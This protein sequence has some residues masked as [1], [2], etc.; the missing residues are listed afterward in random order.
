MPKTK[1]QNKTEENLAKSLMQRCVKHMFLSVEEKEYWKNK[2]PMLS[3][4]ELKKL[5]AIF[6]NFN[7]E[8]K[9]DIKKIC[10]HIDPKELIAQLKTLKKKSLSKVSVQ[11]HEYELGTA[12]AKLEDSL[13]DINN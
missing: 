5:E 10:E 12:E 4:P 1:K 3:N 13:K 2:I 6:N 9:E 8:F 7:N 11:T